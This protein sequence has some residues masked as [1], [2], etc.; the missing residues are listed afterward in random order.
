MRAFLIVLAA[1]LAAEAAYAARAGFQAGVGL[2]AVALA[3]GS[4]AVAF[5]ATAAGMAVMVAGVLAALLLGGLPDEE[6]G[7]F[8]TLTLRLAGG[9]GA[10][11]VSLW[12]TAA[13]RVG[14]AIAPPLT[15]SLVL[16]GL[17]LAS[18]AGREGAEG[19]ARAGAL[20]LLGMSLLEAV[21]RP[22]EPLATL[23]VSLSVPV[24]VLVCRRS[25]APGTDLER[26]GRRLLSAAAV[27]L[28]ALAFLVP[29]SATVSGVHLAFTTSGRWLVLVTAAGLLGIALSRPVQLPAPHPPGLLGIAATSVLIVGLSDPVL[30]L[31]AWVAQL[32]FALAAWR[33]RGPRTVR[34][35]FPP[36]LAVAAGELLAWAMAAGTAGGRFSGAAGLLVGGGLALLLGVLPG[37]GSIARLYPVNDRSSLVWWLLMAPA[38]IALALR[39]LAPGG[40]LA[41]AA[42]LLPLLAVLG[43][44]TALVAAVEAVRE[45]DL[46]RLSEQSGRFAV[47]LILVGIASGRPLGVAGGLLLGIDLCLGRPMFA[48]LADLVSRRMGSTAVGALSEA[49]PPQPRL[50]GALL[51]GLAALGGVP[52][53]AGF[54]SRVLIYRAAFDAGWPAGIVAL[55]AG[56]LW[57]YVS[58]H[59]VGRVAVLPPRLR[60]GALSRRA[61][62]LAWLP[63]A[64]ALALGLQPGRLARWLI[65]SGG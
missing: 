15:V 31:G 33:E 58:L 28:G 25:V 35:L 36:A 55:T 9:V 43:A 49:L 48:A 30:W 46:V 14:P 1:L 20:A 17:G 19:T 38:L 4:A 32:G 3:A 24:W 63:A 64:L 11:A 53:F 37:R 7:G 22:A 5:G 6:S 57:L 29:A 42:F 51:L 59:L 2:T 21:S 39:L 41:G 18:F 23:L 50:R 26:P 47:G 12:L 27:A 61:L 65:G 13:L 52:P 10:V 62:A 34:V 16:L 40:R 45:A 60:P 54:P 8:G 44:F 56:A